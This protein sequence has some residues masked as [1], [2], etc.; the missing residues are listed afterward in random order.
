MPSTSRAGSLKDPEISDLFFKEDP[1]KLFTDLREI[2]HGSFGAVYFVCF[3]YLIGFVI[4]M[5][6]TVHYEVFGRLNCEISDVYIAQARDARTAEV[7]AIK[8]MSYSGK[9]SNEVNTNTTTR[10]V[11]VFLVVQSSA[12]WLES[13]CK[14]SRAS[15]RWLYV[16]ARWWLCSKT[17]WAASLGSI[18][19]HHRQTSHTKDVL[20]WLQNQLLFKL[21]LRAFYKPLTQ[22]LVNAIS[23]SLLLFLCL[24]IFFLFEYE[25]T[26]WGSVSTLCQK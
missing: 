15:C 25:T 3:I 21:E 18:F 13:V 22:A 11:P 4:L 19:R 17:Y 23:S 1:E 5:H 12:T 2:G 20:K 8:K 26:C 7:V 14:K 10:S 6:F 16:R 24:M 9:Q